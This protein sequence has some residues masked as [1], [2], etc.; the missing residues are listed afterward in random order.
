MFTY[1]IILIS[2]HIDTARIKVVNLNVEWNEYF[3]RNSKGT[4]NTVVGKG[5]RYGLNGPGSNP[6]VVTFPRSSRLL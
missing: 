6:G 3:Y 1:D 4:R 2:I 5:A